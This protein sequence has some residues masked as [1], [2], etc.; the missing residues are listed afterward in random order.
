MQTA[1]N[2]LNRIHP[3]AFFLKLSKVSVRGIS[4]TFLNGWDFLR[5]VSLFTHK[6]PQEV[7]YKKGVLKSFAK[8]TG[9]LLWWSHFLIKLQTWRPATLLEETPTQV[10]SCEYSEILKNIYFKEW[11]RMV[12]VFIT[13]RI[14]AVALIEVA[15]HTCFME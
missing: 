10:F 4:L 6:Q 13:Q 14:F 11:L 1:S 5:M 8:F 3:L 7:F 9:K 15:L 12:P 2:P